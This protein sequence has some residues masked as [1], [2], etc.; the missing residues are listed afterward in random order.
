MSNYFILHTKKQL[1]SLEINLENDKLILQ[2][3][4]KGIAHICCFPK[5]CYENNKEH[6]YWIE[7]IMY[8]NLYGYLEFFEWIK[9]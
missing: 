5:M 3:I 2:N 7:Y 6:F 8:F 9:K 4:T 1:K